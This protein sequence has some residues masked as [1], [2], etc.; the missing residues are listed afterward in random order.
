MSISTAL[1]SAYS[2]LTTVSR[3]AQTVSDNVANAMNEGY[4]SRSVVTAQRL[5]G[6]IGMGVRVETVDRAVNALATATRRAG[7]ADLGYNSTRADA[8]TRMSA[9]LGQPG[10]SDALAS[11]MAAFENSLRGAAEAPHSASAQVDVL[12]KAFDLGGTLNNISTQTSVVRMEADASI[13]RQVDSVNSALK[14]IEAVN[15]A[16]RIRFGS[17]DTAALEDERKRLLDQISSIIP[18]KLVQREKGTVAVYSKNGAGLLEGQARQL[19]FTPTPTITHDMTLA[20]TA[21]SGISINGRLVN[22]G[23]GAGMLDGGSLA[24]TFEVR[25]VIAPEFNAQI[26]AVAR[27]LVERFQDPA[28][29]PTLLPGDAGLFTDSGAGFLP[30]DELGIAGRVMINAA[31]DPAQGGAVWRIRDGIGAVIAGPAGDDSQL[32]R[33]VDTMMAGRTPSAASGLIN[34]VT[35][36]DIVD[37]ITSLLAGSA[38]RQEEAS[39]FHSGQFAILR[40]GELSAVGVDTDYEMQQLLMVEQ[41]YAANARVVSTLDSL[42]QTLLEM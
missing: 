33:M 42:M 19:E 23:S 20:S 4:S 17:G 2:G 39:A 35:A 3:M 31:V 26:D 12:A 37:G 25:D 11:K 38:H 15:N 32:R 14:Q 7:G 40:E 34:Q 1:S 22:M 9:L 10:D 28:V 36:T 5:A 8:M 6:G 29:D 13:E 21:L 24:A 18:I 30:V 27:D 41:A 16:I